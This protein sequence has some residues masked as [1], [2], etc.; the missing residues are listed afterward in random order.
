MFARA[1]ML[2]SAVAVVAVAPAAADAAGPVAHHAPI[3]SKVV[4]FKS[5]VAI[6]LGMTS[7]A[8]LRELGK[9]PYRYLR[10]GEP[11]GRR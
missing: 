4:L 5:I 9:P 2:L 6:K 10:T 1:R 11:G 7:Q 3:G 8:V